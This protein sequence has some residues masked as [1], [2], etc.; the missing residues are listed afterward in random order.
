MLFEKNCY[1]IKKKKMDAI[2]HVDVLCL[3]ERVPQETMY[4]GKSSLFVSVPVLKTTIGIVKYS[5][6][7]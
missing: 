7:F 2:Q 4:L 6:Y 5:L 1:C 3:C